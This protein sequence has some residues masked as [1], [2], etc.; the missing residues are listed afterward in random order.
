MKKTKHSLTK[1]LVIPNQWFNYFTAN[2]HLLVEEFKINIKCAVGTKDNSYFFNYIRR[3]ITWNWLV[4][5]KE[6]IYFFFVQQ[7]KSWL[8]QSI[9][10]CLW[11][12]TDLIQFGP[13]K[14]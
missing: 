3:S 8:R 6:K 13:K 5:F 4:N 7:L 12:W 9:L 1:L 2:L 10:P 11:T 14:I